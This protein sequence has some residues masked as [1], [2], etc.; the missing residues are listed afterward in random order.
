MM[1]GTTSIGG[2]VYICR[3]VQFRNGFKFNLA[4]FNKLVNRIGNEPSNNFPL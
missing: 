3:G 4:L 2:G 1:I